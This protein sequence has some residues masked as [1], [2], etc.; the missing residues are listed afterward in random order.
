MN[1]NRVIALALV[2]LVLLSGCSSIDTLT[3]SSTQTDTGPTATPTPDTAASTDTQTSAPDDTSTQIVKTP[4]PTA[5]AIP[6]ETWTKPATPKAPESKNEN[7]I[8]S[9]EIVNKEES[10]NGSGYTNFDVQ[11]NADTSFEDIDPT[12]SVDGEPYFVVE[13]N[14]KIVARN[15][16]NLRQDGTFTLTIRP[17]ALEQFDSGTLDVKVTLYDEDHK[18]DDRYG[19]WTGTV[20]YTA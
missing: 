9:A 11:V 18:H 10:S 17:G 1:A 13:I 4:P 7:N 19:K 8:K 20:K 12:P 6:T 2:S 16:V 14:D 3:G 5:T 15:D